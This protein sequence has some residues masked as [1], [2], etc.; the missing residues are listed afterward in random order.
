MEISKI[1]N[2]MKHYL[3]LFLLAA[4]A[5]NAAVAQTTTHDVLVLLSSDAVQA[6]GGE[7]NAILW[8]SQEV[9]TAN[10]IY[11]NS[12][13][14][15]ALRVA[16]AVAFNPEGFD[17]TQ[18]SPGQIL[19]SIV[20]AGNGSYIN[21]PSSG[22]H[23]QL[24]NELRVKYGAD[25]VSLFVSSTSNP[26]IYGQASD[27]PRDDFANDQTRIRTA[28]Y[29]VTVLS[30]TARSRY[31]FAHE[32]GHCLGAGH[33]GVYAPN[34]IGWTDSA[35]GYLIPGTVPPTMTIMHRTPPSNFVR[36][37]F[38]STA[39][40][41][42]AHNGWPLGNASSNNAAAVSGSRN[43]I[44]AIAVSQWFADA[45]ISINEWRGGAYWFGWF[46]VGSYPYVWHQ[47][48]NR[49]LLATSN[50]ANQLWFWDYTQGAY[51][52]TSNA[53]WPWVWNDSQKLWI[54]LY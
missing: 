2:H 10:Q 1:K 36:I 7:S 19:E 8:A 11:A 42:I 52:W 9:A 51:I 29:S 50:T 22:V 47:A 49:W 43:A 53:Y 25:L 4:S 17:P 6:A 20:P 5:S 48:A 32:V 16:G 13:T 40:T 28:S 14:G 37:P 46:W 44:N 33:D 15:V 21:Y 18:M 41:S 54:K 12:R 24:V 39:D 34:T 38:L 23:S 26:N 3:K 35:R 45:P 27:I 31:T 30:S